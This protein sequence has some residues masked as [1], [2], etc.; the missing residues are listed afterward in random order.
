[1]LGIVEIS[2][3][4]ILVEDCSNEFAAFTIML[5]S[6]MTFTLN[7]VNFSVNMQSS[8]AI[9]CINIMGQNFDAM[10][11][12]D[13]IQTPYPTIFLKNFSY[14]LGNFQFSIHKLI[15]STYIDVIA[16]SFSMINTYL[17]S[18]SL[19]N[20]NPTFIV[21]FLTFSSINMTNSKFM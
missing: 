16:E 12:P 1:M 2:D 5:S 10:T 13:S 8:N 11:T 21:F 17:T 9:D 18:T 7:N 14:S 19:H 6:G 15:F 3:M 4:N 20:Y